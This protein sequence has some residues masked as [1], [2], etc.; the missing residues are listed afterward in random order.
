MKRFLLYSKLLCFAAFP[1]AISHFSFSQNI[2]IGTTIPAGKLQINHRSANNL[3]GLFLVDS[4]ASF[5]GLVRFKNLSSSKYM[6]LWGYYD[7]IYSNNQYL[8]VS[9]D[10]TFVATFRGNGNVGIGNGLPSYRLDVSGAINSSL[11][12]RLWGK[13]FFRWGYPIGGMYQD[14][15][16]GDSAGVSITGGGHNT[17]IG[18]GSG[19]F[20]TTGFSN[21]FIGTRAGY[22]CVS[23][24]DNTFVGDRAGEQ[25]NGFNN[26]FLGSEAGVIN[27]SGHNNTFLGNY[28]GSNNTAGSHN[29]FLGTVS[30]GFNEDGAN[31]VFIGSLA[32]RSNISGNG[33]TLLGYLSDLGSQTLDNATAIGQHALATQSN[34]LILGGINGVNGAP[35]DTRVGIGTTTPTEKLEVAGNI[36]LTGELNRLSTGAANLVPITFGTISSAGAILSGSGNFTVTKAGT[37]SYDIT[38]TGNSYIYSDYSALVTTIGSPPHVAATNSFSGDLLIRVYNL[39]GVL[40]DGL[41]QFVVYKQ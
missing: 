31:N 25:T 7:G 5:S 16:I 8:D 17:F 13:P 41:F 12:Y 3:P 10:S 14:L 27:V 32:G 34:T 1:M 29:I 24:H 35:A 4:T 37:G 26:T 30:G 9:S 40:T 23:G 21:C 38:I 18:G 11:E 39:S 2:G 28:T 20:N 22:R 19:R 33:N 6:Q 15:Y 36:K